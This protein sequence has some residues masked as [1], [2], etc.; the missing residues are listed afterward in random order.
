MIT[1]MQTKHY[2]TPACETDGMEPKAF[3]CASTFA[4]T[5]EFNDFGILEM[6]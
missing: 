4:T 5:E 2:Q 1:Q 6:E 3:L